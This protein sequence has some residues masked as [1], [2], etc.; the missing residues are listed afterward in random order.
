MTKS[1]FIPIFM[2][3]SFFSCLSIAKEES[4]PP[5]LSA[6]EQKS[7]DSLVQT[8]VTLYGEKRYEDAARAFKAA[9]EIQPEP[10][11]AYNI[12][13]SY[14][15]IARSES[16]LE[17][18]E[19][20]IDM[21]G[22]T[23]ELRARAL[24]NMAALRKEIAARKASEAAAEAS[25]DD[26]G[27]MAGASD[28]GEGAT[29]P[30][31]ESS[32]EMTMSSA[33]SPDREAGA[34]EKK[35]YLRSKI[36]GWWLTGIGLT[37]MATGGAFGVLAMKDKK[38]Y[39]DAGNSMDRLAY[40][41]DVKKNA[42]LFDVIFTTGIAVTSVG[43]SLLVLYAVKNR[44]TRE[45]LAAADGRRPIRTSSPRVT[46]SFVIGNGTFAGALVARF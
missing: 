1:L 30:T 41:D 21:P 44:G 12:A 2:I 25:E 22:T 9:F 33:Q 29:A 42:L 45:R 31:G 37:V 14:E 34:P 23:G 18:Y 28:S 46:P 26:K 36:A 5:K 6:D 19:K 11:L 43:I 17:W 40:R 10:E 8:G 27:E 20:F 35:V 3:V 7:Y 13:R 32:E 39:D 16:A 38:D 15:R 4:D 24:E